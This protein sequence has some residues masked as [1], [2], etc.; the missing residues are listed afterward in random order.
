MCGCKESPHFNETMYGSGFCDHFVN[1]P[2]Q[3][4]YSE[5]LVTLVLLGSSEQ[6]ELEARDVIA[7]LEGALKIGLP[8]DDEMN[9]RFS[10]GETYFKLLRYKPK[11]A[12]P[13]SYELRRAIQ[14]M[15]AS[16][17]ID[18]QEGYGHFHEPIYSA[19]L[20]TLAAAYTK[21]SQQTQKEEGPDCA[22]AYVKQKL[23][24]FNYLSSPPSLLLLN[25]GELYESKCEWG[26]AHTI[27]MKILDRAENPVDD[28]DS[29]VRRVARRRIR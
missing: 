10:L 6:H 12:W 7:K 18:S 20:Q 17:I 4:L 23:G 5:A 2:A 13:M 11:E 22:I 27:F 9:A 1:N 16:V 26:Y 24:L 3:D 28:I 29:D 25:L 8:Q 19:R 21:V 14:E 15:E